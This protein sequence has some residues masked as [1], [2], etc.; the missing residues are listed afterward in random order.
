MKISRYH[1]HDILGDVVLITCALVLAF[2]LRF[3]FGIPP[4][5]FELLKTFILPVAVAKLV[6]YYFAGIY[7]RIWRYAGIRDFYTIFWSSILGTLAATVIIFFI[8]RG[9]FP[10]SVIIL[11]GVLT[12][13]FIGGLRFVARGIRELRLRSFLSPAVKPILIAGAGDTGEAILRE[14][15]NHPQLACHPVGFIDDD[16]NKQGLRLHGVK[17]LGT[18]RQLRQLINYHRIEEVIISMPSVSREVIRD[19]FFQ[20]QEE[21]VKCKTLPGIY[22]IV[23][24]TARVEQIRE[25]GVGDILGREP[26]KTDLKKAVGYIFGK[27]ILVSGAGGSIGSELCRQISRLQPSTLLM[28]DQSESS[29]FQIEQELVRERS[30][31][32]LSAVVLDITNRPRTEAIFDRYKPAVVFHAA[33]YKHVPLMESNPV[34][35]IENNLLTT[36]TLAELAIKSGVERFVAISTDKAVEPT[37][38]M[39][40]SKALA[41][42]LV[43]ML[44]QDSS[45]TK[46][47]IV[48]FGNV[49]DSSGSVVPIFRQ[50]IARG[51][52]VTVTHP[53]MARYFMTIP[54]ATQ[55]VIQ[56]GAIGQGGEIF[57]LDMGEQVSILEL[58][59]N[60]IRL[61]GFEPEK[62][63]PIEFS[64]IRP[65]EKLREK[66]FWDYEEVV[67][68]EYEKILRVKSTG[69]DIAKLK[70]DIRQLETAVN[71]CDSGGIMEKLSRTYGFQMDKTQA[72]EYR[73]EKSQDTRGET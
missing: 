50:Q 73:T 27:S 3:D 33:A 35:A 54:E 30:P 9:P 39:G 69:L 46:F 25:V 29:L 62:D 66:L 36:R 42:K 23:D 41:E 65:G 2:F 6:I 68:T 28:V 72:N 52:P 7:R 24:G 49:L 15:L 57:V 40:A 61:S 64:S 38:V 67:P 63:I 18:R 58:A 60:M 8:Y 55:L 51:G 4:E 31:A 13:A 45:S 34:E 16:P 37:S 17:V 44:A 71:A 21:G 53:E 12:V 47:M 14:I 26:I 43:Q 70:E 1:I 11:D 19:I 10:R 56:A 48:R 32:S 22:Q 59:K 20:C 5:Q